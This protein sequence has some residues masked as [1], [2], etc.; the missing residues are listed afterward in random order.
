MRML[1]VIVMLL[2]LGVVLSGCPSIPPAPATADQIETAAK[3]AQVKLPP[4]PP[5]VMVERKPNFRERLLQIFSPSPTTPTPSST[6][7]LPVR[8]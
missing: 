3:A 4:A 6:N 1:C 2:T 5:D 8:Q 7:S